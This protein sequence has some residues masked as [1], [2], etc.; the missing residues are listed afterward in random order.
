[1]K[2]PLDEALEQLNKG[3]NLKGTNFDT[4]LSIDDLPVQAELLRS[5]GYG[6]HYSADPQYFKHWVLYTKGEADQ[7]L[8]IEPYTWLPDAP[9]LPFSPEETG[10]IDLQPGQ[11]VELNVNLNIIY[12]STQAEDE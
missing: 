6:L 12:P 3:L 5:D 4:L 10:L 11:V 8:C 1:M 7:F 2:A 9:N